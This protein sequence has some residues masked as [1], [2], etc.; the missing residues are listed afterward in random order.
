MN[1]RDAVVDARPEVARLLSFSGGGGDDGRGAG[2]GVFAVYGTGMSW[3]FRA[4]GE[5]G[6]AEWILAIDR[7]FLGSGSSYGGSGSGS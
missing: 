7:A 1:L 3:V 2:D 4:R 6:K 5:V